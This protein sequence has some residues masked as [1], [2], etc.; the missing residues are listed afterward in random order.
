MQTWDRPQ[1]RIVSSSSVQVHHFGPQAVARAI[2]GGDVPIFVTQVETPDGS[3]ALTQEDFPVDGI[4]GIPHDALLIFGGDASAAIV[5]TVPVNT[6]LVVASVGR[7]SLRVENYHS[8]M[9]L[10]LH[11]GGIDVSNSSGAAYVQA[12]RGSIAVANSNFDRIRARTAIGNIFF[13]GCNVRQVEVSSVRGHIAYDNGTFAPGL[14]RFETQ[15]GNIALGVASGGVH[16]TAHAS[17]GRV[18]SG[19]ERNAG[20]VAGSPTD[21]EATINGGGPIVTANAGKGSIFIY[22]GTLRG[23]PRIERQ[24]PRAPRAPFKAKICVKPRCRV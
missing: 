23:K 2:P 11:N 5:I 9:V 24:L 14:A 8:A 21:A 15:E 3:I 10:L 4:A 18:V 12:A 17:G 6:A 16:V 22:S 7:G 20:T 13:T 19:L 1:V